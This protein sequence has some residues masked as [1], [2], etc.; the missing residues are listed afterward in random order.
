MYINQK[1]VVSLFIASTSVN[2]FIPS[3]SSFVQNAKAPSTSVGFK[4]GLYSV[5][6]SKSETELI[7]ETK[8]VTDEAATVEEKA[9][10]ILKEEGS[11]NT[12]A[13]ADDAKPKAIAPTDAYEVAAKLEEAVVKE[14][15]TVEDKTILDELDLVLAIEEEADALVDEMMDD[16]CEI[17]EE[18]NPADEICV[19][20][21]KLALVKSKLKSVVKKTIGLVRTGG[22]GNSVDSTDVFG[23]GGIDFDD[24]VVLEGELLEQGWEQRGNS[25]AI[26]R[27][28]E[29]WKFA[30]S[31][32]FKALKPKKMRKKGA[33]E[34]EIQA[35][36]S[37][38]AIFIRNGLLK[39]GPSFVKLGQVVSTRTDVLPVEYTDVLKT[40][41]DDVP[42]FSGKRAKE[43]V[44][45]ELGRP[46]DE[47]FQDFSPQPLAA[48]SLGQVHTAMY[49]GKR[50]A[51]KVQRAG[52]KE[53][54]DTDLQNLKKL[55]VLLDKFD[56][57]TDGADRNWV[58]IYEESERLL[59]E[60][61]DYIKE[62]NNADRFAKDF[63]DTSWVRV[64]SVVRAQTT[65]RVLTMEYVESFKLTDIERVEKEGLDR[66]LLAKRTAD[67]FLKQIVQTGYF[68]CDPHPG[69]L[70]VDTKGNLVFYDYGMMD[71]LKP[72]VR[73][74]F[75]KFCTALF[76]GGPMISD[77]DLA[78]NAKILVDGVEEAGVLA[79]GADR[80]A[81][82]K[83][84]RFFM[85]SFKDKQLGKS[86]GNIKETIGTD[87]QTLTENNVFRFPSTFTF[88]FRSFASIDG[89]GKGLDKNYDIGKL[90]Q[91]FIE[92]F[93]EDQ[94]GPSTPAEKSFNIFRAATGL[95]KDDINTAVTSPKKIAYIEETMRSMESGSLKIRVRSLENE[96]ALERMELTQGRME[97]ILLAS[98]M[99]NVAGI[100]GGP[101]VS[102]VGLAGAANFGFQ[103]F[104]TNTKIKKFDKTQAKFVQTKFVDD[105][106][107]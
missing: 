105:E 32:V 62:A 55:A 44:T 74:G 54:F 106:E 72:N 13:V 16:T 79:R 60:E 95:N 76:A 51:I 7:K 65:P 63:K 61:I 40:L 43:I 98:V 82:E 35:A 27:N 41:Q 36:K 83:L 17:D 56:P 103:A 37:E 78:K 89:I 100:A 75:R 77:L 12:T 4:T 49:K 86:S 1:A 85:R 58:S 94:K 22:D 5:V 30:L 90:A 18:G 101:I 53:L 92:K 21:S 104:M 93:T 96:K 87:L 34:A 48:A 97:N 3:S 26:R 15:E 67:A 2:A 25:S 99:L 68:H 59:Y 38:A 91:P 23:E 64:P 80:L 46:C 29:V 69:N 33:S 19:D 102:A 24:G 6:D 57:K 47:I 14:V 73:S 81:V 70:C 10:K 31:C 20:E 71:E 45:K 50:V 66:E 9:W 39:L 11:T 88:I 28:A 42:G 52:L 84:A 107:N 8:V